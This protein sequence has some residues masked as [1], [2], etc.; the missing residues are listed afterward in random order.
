M[1]PTVQVG[2]R[3]QPAASASAPDSALAPAA[4]GDDGAGGD[5]ADSGGDAADGEFLSVLA[6]DPTDGG[7]GILKP[8]PYLA[9]L[10][11]Y[12][13]ALLACAR[14]STEGEIAVTG[15]IEPTGAASFENLKGG[16]ACLIEI[17]G[18]ATFP[19]VQNRIGIVIV[20]TH[21]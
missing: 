21:E 1:A 13:R 18:R 10:A 17:V 8:E 15:W 6:S 2:A 9:A 19:G 7:L 16:E 3:A 14:Q 5:E 12:R 4:S 20:V 11:P